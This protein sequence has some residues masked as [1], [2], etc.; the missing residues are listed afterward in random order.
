M[1]TAPASVGAGNEPGQPSPTDR[2]PTVSLAASPLPPGENRTAARAT[3]GCTPLASATSVGSM[4]CHPE[5]VFTHTGPLAMS[6]VS[7]PSGFTHVFDVSVRSA[8]ASTR[9]PCARAA[10]AAD[11]RSGRTVTTAGFAADLTAP[12]ARDGAANAGTSDTV[13][14]S[15]NAATE[16]TT[17]MP[18]RQTRS[19]KRRKRELRYLPMT[20]PR[21]RA[22]HQWGATQSEYTL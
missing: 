21:V 1:A 15:T 20:T 10:N 9:D 14:P 5:S 7:V 18:R 13:A 16:A 2:D 8:S 19:V 11:T 6:L 3:F 4:S 22:S 17:G 12:G